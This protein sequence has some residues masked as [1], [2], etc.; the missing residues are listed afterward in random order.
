MA[1]FSEICQFQTAPV[2]QLMKLIVHPW[3][4]I[5]LVTHIYCP[6]LAINLVAK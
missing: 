3:P 5:L 1:S 4:P 2:G 6:F